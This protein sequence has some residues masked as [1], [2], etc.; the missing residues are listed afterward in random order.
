LGTKVTKTW[1]I[2]LQKYENKKYKNI[3]TKVTKIWE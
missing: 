3:G 2:K 1:K